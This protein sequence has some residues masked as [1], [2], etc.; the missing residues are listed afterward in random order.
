MKKLI[1]TDPVRICGS[2]L[3]GS[4]IRNFGWEARMYGIWQQ[5]TKVMWTEQKKK[6]SSTGHSRMSDYMN[7]SHFGAPLP[8]HPQG[9]IPTPQ[10]YK[11][12]LTSCP[13][14]LWPHCLA[15][16]CLRLCF[17]REQHQAISI[18]NRIPQLSQS[19]GQA[20]ELHPRSNGLSMGPINKGNLWNRSVSIVC[21]LW[22]Q[23][24]RG[25]KTLPIQLQSSPWIPIQLVHTQVQWSIPVSLILPIS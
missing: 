9:P 24:D 4:D 22:P 16:E 2:D 13:S 8:D 14:S 23:P 10:G 11:P 12:K 3:I 19:I 7:C 21:L 1:V 20:A 25:R 15:C 18:H 5:Q 6:I 17:C